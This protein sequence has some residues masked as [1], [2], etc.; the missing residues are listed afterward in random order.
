M[1]GPAITTT[2]IRQAL[3]DA[4]T[5]LEAAG[6]ENPRMEARLLMGFVIGGG[7]EKVLAERD[8]QMT[9][10]EID[11]FV[12][13][14]NRRCGHEPMAYITGTREFYSLSFIVSTATL[15]PRPDSET[16]IDG[17]IEHMA[18]NEKTE[19]I[20]ILDLGT[21]SGCLLLS[22]LSEISASSGSGIDASKDA[23]EIAG[24]NATQLGLDGRAN[25]LNIDWREANW[26]KKLDGK[27]DLVVSN[28]PYITDDEM[29]NLDPTVRDFEPLAALGGGKD[30]L[31]SYKILI[32]QLDDIL[33]D[34][35]LVAFETG[36]SQA[37]LVADLL[38]QKGLQ[39]VEIKEDLSG[40]ARAVLARKIKS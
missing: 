32:N 36:H 2:I 18:A 11:R 4:T 40:I 7:P 37:R 8:R 6:M 28:P 33:N 23:L 20:R 27:F 31:D 9:E 10:A 16:V 13:C 39:V 38:V 25:F 1:T 14:L 22:L 21:G 34:G 5:K 26:T 35:G 17:A 29:E 3:S 12:Q 15:I 24:Q 19:K 30:G